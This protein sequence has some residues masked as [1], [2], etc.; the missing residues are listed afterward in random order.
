MIRQFLRC[1]V[2]GNPQPLFESSLRRTDFRDKKYIFCRR[3]AQDN[4]IAMAWRMRTMICQQ[5]HLL[6]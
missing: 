2:T 1:S 5:R 4:P 6:T 3:Y